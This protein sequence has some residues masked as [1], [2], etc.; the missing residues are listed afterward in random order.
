MVLTLR[1]LPADSW[2]PG[3]TPLQE[4]RSAAVGNR[5]AESGPGGVRVV[6]ALGQF[7]QGLLARGPAQ[8]CKLAEL[9]DRVIE[10]RVGALDCLVRL[11]DLDRKSVV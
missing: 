6:E 10:I 8:Q 9:P 7:L 3:H 2:L 4:A 5:F 1:R 11:A